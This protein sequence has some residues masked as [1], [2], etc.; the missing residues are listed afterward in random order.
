MEVRR[1]VIAAAVLASVPVPGNSLETEETPS[2]APVFEQDCRA[3][4]DWL[5]QFWR[6][7]DDRR[8]ES[9]PH[10]AQ[11]LEGLL[12]REV[13]GRPLSTWSVRG[14]DYLRGYIDMAKNDL[15]RIEADP[16]ALHEILGVPVAVD[17]F[18]YAVAG[19]WDVD[20]DP[21]YFVWANRIDGMPAVMHWLGWTVERADAGP[22]SLVTLDGLTVLVGTEAMFDQT[23]HLRGRPY[24]YDVG[25][26]RFTIITESEA[27]AAE[28]LGRLC[29]DP[30]AVSARFVEERIERPAQGYAVSFP[31]DWV[32]AEV[33]DANRDWMDD[34]ADP[35]RLSDTQ[36]MAQRRGHYECSVIDDTRYAEAPPAYISLAEL[37][38]EVVYWA[39]QDPTVVQFEAAYVE[40]AA[41]QTATLDALYDDGT[42]GRDYHFTDMTTWFRLSCISSEPPDDRWL[43]IAETFE[44][45]PVEG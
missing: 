34:L 26:V 39:G 43:S 1:S 14:L 41:G 22:W 32:V 40:L 17:D 29:P 4:S 3:S 11:D 25:D 10:Q 18:E 38:D 28:A 15:E 8:W 30:A 21:P 42:I 20:S 35:G 9:R 31:I 13:A 24:V 27:W 45:L 12:P 19:R 37:V 6:G 44:F 2:A 16:S 36:L 5:D 23:E 33:T 7:I